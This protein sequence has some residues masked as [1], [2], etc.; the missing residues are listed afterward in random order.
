MGSSSDNTALL[1]L[2]V[3]DRGLKAGV[4]VFQNLS[5]VSSGIV[6]HI[7]L[8]ATEEEKKNGISFDLRPP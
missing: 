8:G 7:A 4:G 1:F 2:K 6:V 3:G 5:E